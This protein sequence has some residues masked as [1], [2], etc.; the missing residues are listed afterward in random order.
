MS[1]W[2]PSGEVSFRW[3]TRL[4]IGC[5]VDSLSGPQ[6]LP[7]PCV[8]ECVASPHPRPLHQPTDWSTA[9]SSCRPSFAAA[10]RPSTA[11]AGKACFLSHILRDCHINTSTADKTGCS[12]ALDVDRDFHRTP[13]PGTAGCV[14]VAASPDIPRC[15]EVHDL[16]PHHIFPGG[17]Q[18]PRNVSA[19][20][21]WRLWC[22]S[23]RT[24]RSESVDRWS[25]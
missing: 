6:D 7:D 2:T 12:E 10:V 14:P 11:A 3:S 5:G 21:W 18:S 23:H 16:R 13:G 19:G 25:C 9:H 1:R 22:C 20:G 4:M 24:N 17:P 8:L 15:F